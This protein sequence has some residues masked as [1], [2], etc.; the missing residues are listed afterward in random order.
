MNGNR[1]NCRESKFHDSSEKKKEYVGE[2]G[3]KYG[4][5]SHSDSVEIIG[6]NFEY[7]SDKKRV[8]YDENG[9]PQILE[10][11]GVKIRLFGRF[12]DTTFFKLSKF[13]KC[14]DSSNREPIVKVFS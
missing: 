6:M 3:Q 11:M 5:S 13:H 4:S 10:G 9:S 14:D 2:S 12:D 7:E 8:E 1:P